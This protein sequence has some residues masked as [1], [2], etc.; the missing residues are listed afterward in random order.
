MINKLKSNLKSD[1]DTGDY[2]IENESYV[3]KIHTNN[4]KAYSKLKELIKHSFESYSYFTNDIG[5]KIYDIYDLCDT[6]IDYM[7]QDL[8]DYGLDPIHI[9]KM[10]IRHPRFPGHTNYLAYF[11]DNDTSQW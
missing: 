8:N 9:K 3:I 1:F 5:R 11:D 2:I 10:T 6:D 4:M 7:I